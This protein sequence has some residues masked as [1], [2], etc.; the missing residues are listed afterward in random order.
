M[1]LIQC[2]RKIENGDDAAMAVLV[3]K[4]SRRVKRL[5]TNYLPKQIRHLESPEDISSQAMMSLYDLAQKGKLKGITDDGSLW[6]MVIRLVKCL[7]IDR[8]DY[9]MA[10]KRHP[11]DDFSE[12]DLNGLHRNLLRA[13]REP[14]Y[15]PIL[16]QQLID[17]IPR[18]E[19]RELAELHLDEHSTADISEKLGIPDY[20][21]R[22]WLK[23]VHGIWR[24]EYGEEER[25]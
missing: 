23:T 13:E 25:K 1:S 3:D 16:R 2:V 4:L 21:V 10:K 19:L 9:Y 8:T 22:R 18:A 11:D 15:W 6:A 24:E 14:E 5:A 12:A 7:A 17:C 20:T